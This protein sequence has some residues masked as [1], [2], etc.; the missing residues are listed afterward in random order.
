MHQLNHS[1]IKAAEVEMLLD[2]TKGMESSKAN[3]S[4]TVWQVWKESKE[5]AHKANFQ[6]IMDRMKLKEAPPLMDSYGR[7]RNQAMK[8]RG[9][10]LT[11]G[12]ITRDGKAFAIVVGAG[13]IFAAAVGTDKLDT[14]RQ[15]ATSWVTRL[16]EAME[17]EGVQSVLEEWWALEKSEGGWLELMRHRMG[18]KWTE[19]VKKERMPQAAVEKLDEACDGH[20]GLA[21]V[22]W[23]IFRQVKQR[24][25]KASN[26]IRMK[27]FKTRD[28]DIDEILDT[29]ADQCL[30]ESGVGVGKIWKGGLEEY[31]IDGQEVFERMREGIARC[32]ILAIDTEGDGGIY[33]QVGWVGENVLEAAV[34]GPHFLPAEV[35]DLIKDPT[36]YI[37]GKDVHD[38]LSLILGRKKGLKAVELSVLTLDLPDSCEDSDPRKSSLGQLAFEATAVSFEHIKDPRQKKEWRKF[39]S[40]RERGWDKAEIDD[41]KIVY[42][43]LDVTMP[44]VIIFYYLVHWVN[45]YRKE[46]GRKGAWDVS[47]E[48]LLERA[49]GPVVDRVIDQSSMSRQGAPKLH[50]RKSIR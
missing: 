12:K 10:V 35:L 18:A 30:L 23:R 49:V 3:R 6:L 42:A 1:E 11:A 15:A 27:L 46:G 40:I 32:P 43:A 14:V 41:V 19:M 22:P 8:W 26:N 13:S 44:F 20:K 29:I 24:S 5:D 50:V 16:S 37:G 47:W 33:V 7:V 17:K 21:N 45:S 25:K 4:K 34:F 9:N 2:F 39:S 48:A 38:D 28:R 31:G 36:V